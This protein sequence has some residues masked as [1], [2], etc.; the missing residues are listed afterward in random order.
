MS[1]LEVI[2]GLQEMS[3]SEVI[4]YSVNFADVGVTTLASA[5]IA[6][7]DENDENDVSATVLASVNC[8]VATS[9]ATLAL[10]SALT[11][12]HIYRIEVLGKE[13]TAYKEVFFRVEC[14][15]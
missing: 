10:L 6:A 5:T 9:V 7:Y 3:S 15:K 11:K 14:S 1:K 13:S 8:T 2:E 12:G 4:A